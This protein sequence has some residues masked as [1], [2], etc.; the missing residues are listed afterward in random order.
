MYVWN[1]QLKILLSGHFTY[2]DSKIQKERFEQTYSRLLE[3]FEKEINYR[4]AF[5]ILCCISSCY[6]V[7]GKIM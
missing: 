3:M 7:A 1:N 4:I 5:L 2:R 6:Q